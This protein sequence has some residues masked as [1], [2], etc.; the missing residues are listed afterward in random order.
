MQQR[1]SAMR[2]PTAPAAPT[3]PMRPPW[4]KR[5]GWLRLYND[6][7]THSKWRVVRRLA[8]VHITV[9]KCVVIDLLIAANKGRPRGSIAEFS[10]LECADGNETTTDKVER[11]YAVLQGLGWIDQEHLVTWD[12]RQ[13]DKEDPTAADRQAR[14]RQKIREQNQPQNRPSHRDVTPRQDKTQTLSAAPVSALATGETLTWKQAQEAGYRP[15]RQR[16]LPL[17]PV[18]LNQRGNR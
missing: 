18:P 6:F 13:P 8:R 2:S 9:V 14:R 7:S 3:K 1:G 15:A 10:V 16:S 4:K 5:Y 17:P 12:E 11:V